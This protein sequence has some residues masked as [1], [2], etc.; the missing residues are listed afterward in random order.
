MNAELKKRMCPEAAGS[1]VTLGNCLGTA[2]RYRGKQDQNREEGLSP[3]AGGSAP[4]DFHLL[5]A[6]L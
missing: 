5:L 3:V 1:L 2:E 6:D 4:S